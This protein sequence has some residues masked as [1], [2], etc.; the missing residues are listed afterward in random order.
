MLDDTPVL[1]RK[2]GET[3]Q[4]LLPFLRS[5]LYVF[6]CPVHLVGWIW[7][8]RRESGEPLVYVVG[9]FLATA[10]ILLGTVTLDALQGDA[11]LL[12]RVLSLWG[13][14]SVAWTLVWLVVMIIA[15]EMRDLEIEKKEAA[16]SWV[17]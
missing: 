5:I 11:D 4:V 1:G 12:V 10:W 14:F 17:W 8:K 9:L 13:M 15:L 2:I 3:W 7:A 6:F 16:S